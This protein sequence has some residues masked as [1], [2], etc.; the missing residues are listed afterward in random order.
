[1]PYRFLPFAWLPGLLAAWSSAAAAALPIQG[2]EVKASYPHDPRAFTQ[3]LLYLAPFRDVQERR[4]GTTHRSAM[5][6]ERRRIPY[7]V[8]STT[9][10]KPNFLFEVRHLLSPCGALN[11]VF[12]WREGPSIGEES[13]R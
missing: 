7:E 11:R 5:T 2:V 8:S 12:L 6:P 10:R 4:H 9:I 13:E 1:M 3:G